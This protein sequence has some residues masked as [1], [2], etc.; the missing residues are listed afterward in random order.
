MFVLRTDATFCG[1][2]GVAVHDAAAEEAKLPPVDSLD[3]WPMLS[4]A[5]LTSP[6]REILFTP[7]H[8]LQ[9]PPKCDTAMGQEC[10]EPF[11][12]DPRAVTAPR[13]DALNSHGNDLLDPMII[14][15]PYKLMLGVVDQC[16]WQGPDYPNGTSTWDTHGSWINCT[17][18]TKKACLF[19]A[20]RAASSP[21]LSLPLLLSALWSLLCRH[22]TLSVAAVAHRSSRTRPSTTTSA[23]CQPTHTSSSRCWAAWRNFSRACSTQTAG[24]PRR[25]LQ[26]R[27]SA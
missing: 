11:P 2:A 20:S 10:A 8:G 22:E 4:G 26:R 23:R 7:L 14:I 1:L 25:R 15:G 27:A 19:N 24:R 16:W 13:C 6:R 18:A 5:N 12:C 9:P 17:T 21:F 3:L